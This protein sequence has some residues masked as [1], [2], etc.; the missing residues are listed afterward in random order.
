MRHELLRKETA[1]PIFTG[2]DGETCLVGNSSPLTRYTVTKALPIGTQARMMRAAVFS[3]TLGHPVNAFL[4]INAAHLQRIG[5][6]GIFGLGHLWDGFQVLL[7]LLRKWVTARGVVW[8]VIWSR[9]WSRKG[10]NGQ[11]GEHWHIGLHLPKRFHADLAKQVAEW[12]GQGLST[13]SPT[14]RV[15]AVSEHRAWHLSV[16]HGRGGPEDLAAYLGKAE[17]SKIRRYGRHVPNLYKPRR[18]KIGG[19]GPIEGKRFGISKTIGLT[20]QERAQYV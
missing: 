9:E 6:G 16:K 2:M 15:S 19:E 4:T 18:D 1:Q 20:E 10:I 3:Q 11:A 12:T 17:P 5:E 13:I 7:E 14:A 8:A